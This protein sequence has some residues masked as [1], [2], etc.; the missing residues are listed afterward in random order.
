MRTRLVLIVLVPVLI[1]CATDTKSD[2]RPPV[3]HTPLAL[4]PANPVELGRWWSSGKL[5]LELNDDARYCV[6]PSLNRY[7][8][9]QE[10]GR[11]DRLTYASVQMQPYAHAGPNPQA[12]RA[13][14]ELAADG[15]QL[16]LPA[17]GHF[18]PLARVPS[19]IE[20]RIIGV[21]RSEDGMLRLMSDMQY[22]FLPATASATPMST[23][24]GH[25]GTWRVEKGQ[26]LLQPHASN[27]GPF[28]VQIENPASSDKTAL[29]NDGR[30]MERVTDEM[31]HTPLTQGEE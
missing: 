10:F 4:D 25:S 30:A 24:V 22:R 8:T 17:L 14:L 26:L 20:D 11:W 19:V 15:L 6:Y 1:G 3:T 12:Y 9:P 29:M 7:Q 28:A 21:W 31:T 18:K 5:L 2:P 23:H 16:A 13:T 27:L